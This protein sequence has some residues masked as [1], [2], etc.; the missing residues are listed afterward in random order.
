MTPAALLRGVHGIMECSD[1][2]A[3]TIAIR[4]RNMEHALPYAISRRVQQIR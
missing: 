3:R 1:S 4:S 2:K